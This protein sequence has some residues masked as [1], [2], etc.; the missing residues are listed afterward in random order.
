MTPNQPYAQLQNSPVRNLM[1]VAQVRLFR[2]H[3]KFGTG[4]ALSTMKKVILLKLKA[5]K[6]SIITSILALLI[7]GAGAMRA[8][9]RPDEYLGLPGDNLNLYAVMKLFQESET[10][11]G[12]ERKL[13]EENSRINNLDLNGDNMVDYI[14]VSDYVDG[15]VHTIV[16]RTMLTRNE[17][18][19][20]AVFTVQQFRNGEV[21]IQLIGDEALYGKNYIIEPNYAETPNPGYGGTSVNRSNVTVVTSTY[22]DIGA[23]PMIRFIFHPAYVVWR[24]SWYWGYYPVYWNP[25]RPY[26]WHYYYGY[27]H[28][29]Y[30]HYYQHY[31]HS[32]HHHYAHYNDHYYNHIRTHSPMVST[33]IKE[34]HYRTTYSRPEQRREGEALYARTSATRNTR[35]Q[36][37]NS[38]G[39]GERRTTLQPTQNMRNTT[40]GNGIKRRS[41]E[42]TS[43]RTGTGSSTGQNTAT[44]RRTNTTVTGRPSTTTPAT[45]RTTTTQRS[46]APAVNR[47]A[48]R[49]SST[50]R[51]TTTQR[52]TPITVNRTATRPSSTQHMATTQRSTTPAANRTTTGSSVTQRSATTR[53]SSPAVSQRSSSKPATAVQRTTTSRSSGSSASS[54]RTVSRS[55]SQVSRSA[56]PAAR[57]SGTRSSSSNN[58]NRR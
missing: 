31:H 15:N 27:H 41:T 4:F 46:T 29:W 11:E 54:S 9:D 38:T 51:I 49:P 2:R 36:S 16:L 10:L 45:Q 30:P 55:S 20:V 8:Q 13:N 44:E 22:Y 3:T 56:A 34:G 28:H 21:Q 39:V 32:H 26:Y 57:N 43:Y 25:W 17:S 23:W 12:F 37:G 1:K 40:N 47:T 18:Q 52:S 53:S 6:K 24:S 7:T 58:T 5:M 19:D 35:S 14:T 48:T 50:Q 33:R 42:G